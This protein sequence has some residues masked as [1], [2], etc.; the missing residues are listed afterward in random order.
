MSFPNEKSRDFRISC[1]AVENGSC[2]SHIYA[3]KLEAARLRLI[4]QAIWRIHFDT[5]SLGQNTAMANNCFV[6]IVLEKSGGR[7]AA[8]KSQA[9]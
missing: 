3:P 8:K 7:R 2:V 9:A 4:R 1:V 5:L 6:P